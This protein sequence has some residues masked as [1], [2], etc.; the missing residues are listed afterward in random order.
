[1]VQ[2]TKQENLILSLNKIGIALKKS[3]NVIV[4]ELVGNGLAPL[5]D[6]AID[7]EELLKFALSEIK[8]IRKELKK[9]DKTR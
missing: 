3:H 1:M 4:K 9:N 5:T 6:E 2:L 8:K 7:A